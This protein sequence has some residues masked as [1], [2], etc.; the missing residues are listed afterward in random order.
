MPRL[1]APKQAGDS[2][3]CTLLDRALAP[4]P[5]EKV[6]IAIEAVVSVHWNQVGHSLHAGKGDQAYGW[7]SPSVDHIVRLVWMAFEEAIPCFNNVGHLSTVDNADIGETSLLDHYH[8]GRRVD[9][10]GDFGAYRDSDPINAHL[11]RSLRIGNNPS[12]KGPI[13]FE[14]LFCDWLWRSK[15]RS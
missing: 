2:A 8:H 4:K 5:S 6:V 7:F 12:A 3:C 14:K 1:K 9:V 13:R 11:G 10:E 15:R